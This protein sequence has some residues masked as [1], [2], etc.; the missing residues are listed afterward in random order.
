M[1]F[2]HKLDP[3][4]KCNAKLLYWKNTFIL[5]HTFISVPS[6][7][8]ASRQTLGCSCRVSQVT[9]LISSETPWWMKKRWGWKKPRFE[10]VACIGEVT[11]L[12]RLWL[13]RGW[14]WEKGKGEGW[15]SSWWVRIIRSHWNR[16]AFATKRIFSM[17][18]CVYQYTENRGRIHMM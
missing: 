6:S 7:I 18:K 9:W 3:L 17:H 5:P 4:R 11:V 12:S 8:F 13:R 2:L 15:G 16:N 10:N 14:G 1:Q